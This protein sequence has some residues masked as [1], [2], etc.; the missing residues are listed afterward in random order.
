MSAPRSIVKMWE[1]SS[2]GQALL[3]PWLPCD[4]PG[5][6]GERYLVTPYGTVPAPSPAKSK[7]VAA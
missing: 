2:C 6:S 5:L 1:C 7:Q 3:R 4:C